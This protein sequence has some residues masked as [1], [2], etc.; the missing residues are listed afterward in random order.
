M[1]RNLVD[2]PADRS[3]HLSVFPQVDSALID[4]ELSNDME[5]LLR[6]VSLG[7]AARN[8][9]KIKVRQPLAE[10]KVQGDERDRRAIE[11]FADQVEEELNIKK[12]TFERSENGPLL[13]HE[14]KPNMKTLGP[15]YG[16]RLQRV[17]LAIAAANPV[18]LA[19]Q[20]QAGKPFELNC[21]DGP[22]LLE[23]TDLLVQMKAPDG[24]AGIDDRGTQ[25]VIDTRITELLKREGMAREIVRFVQNA[26]KEA[27]LEMEDRIGLYFYCDSPTLKEALEEHQKYIINETLTTNWATKQ[28]GRDAYK[29]EVK[30]DGQPLIIELRKVT[31]A[32]S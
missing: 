21:A 10:M 5:A 25:V 7:S 17:L 2:G 1:Y 20:I 6:L 32:G 26:R 16:P 18:E 12:L 30:V 23:P 31:I 15:K 8:T 27:G 3:I 28:L 19:G 11:R 24:W 4:Q 9:V 14:I 13:Q 29:A 22:A